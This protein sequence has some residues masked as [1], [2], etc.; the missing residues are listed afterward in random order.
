MLAKL[1][2]L[3]ISRMDKLKEIWPYQAGSSDEV[4]ACMLK[5]ISVMKC[6]NLV[7]LFPRNPMSLLCHLEKLDVSECG[8]IEVLFNI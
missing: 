4:N 7:N 5:A 2:R 3:Q 6:D 1:E 8:S